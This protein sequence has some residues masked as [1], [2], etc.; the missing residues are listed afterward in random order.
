MIAAELRIAIGLRTEYGELFSKA[1][2]ARAARRSRRAATA[3][4]CSLGRVN[5]SP[6][7]QSAA[8]SWRLAG[9]TGLRVERGEHHLL[10]VTRPATC[11]SLRGARTSSVRMRLN[12]APVSRKRKG[13]AAA[14]ADWSV[15]AGEMDAGERNMRAASEELQLY[16]LGRASSRGHRAPRCEREVVTSTLFAS[17][18]MQA[19]VSTAPRG[20]VTLMGAAIGEI[21]AH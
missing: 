11:H 9:V 5:A 17:S 1:A 4:A 21:R 12:A 15:G 13:V 6:R 14:A 3:V 18:R 8:T 2:C 19:S 10:A 20:K 16:E 7:S